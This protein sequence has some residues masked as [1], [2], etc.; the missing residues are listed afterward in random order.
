M[1]GQQADGEWCCNVNDHAVAAHHGILNV[2][3]LHAP[4]CAVCTY[5]LMVEEASRQQHPHA[6]QQLSHPRMRDY[7]DVQHAVVWHGIR[8]LAVA[9]AT[10]HT[11]R[12]HLL[13]QFVLV[14]L[15]VHL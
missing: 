10:A 5:I 15:Q 4:R 2:E 3:E 9:A 12:H 13:L 11:D 1:F 14:D 8:G 7:A 6:F